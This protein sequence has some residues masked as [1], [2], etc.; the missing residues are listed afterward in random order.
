MDGQT[1]KEEIKNREPD[2]L[3]PAKQKVN[4]HTSYICPGC[5]NGSGSSG[6]VIALDPKNTRSKRYKCLVFGLSE[7]IIG[8]WKL[9]KGI[10]MEALRT[11]IKL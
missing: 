4:G 9:H 11:L 6:T 3:K 8:L 7:D 2:F 10:T 1:A 5:N